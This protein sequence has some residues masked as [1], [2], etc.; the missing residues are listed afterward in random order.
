MRAGTYRFHCTDGHHAVL[1]LS[2]RYLRARA[3]L[4]AEAKRVARTI[5]GRCAGRLDW[6]A[7]LV[8]VHDAAGRHVLILMFEEAG[9]AL[10]A[11]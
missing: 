7:W 8:D 4:R 5:M 6:S 9:P 3:D 1:D 11:A 2:G 10:Q